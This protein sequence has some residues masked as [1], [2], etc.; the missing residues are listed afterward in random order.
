MSEVRVFENETHASL[1][2][3]GYERARQRIVLTFR[4]TA[5]TLQYRFIE[6]EEP[7]QRHKVREDGVSL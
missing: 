7:S 5:Y 3:V 1:G 6:H 4:S 2:Y